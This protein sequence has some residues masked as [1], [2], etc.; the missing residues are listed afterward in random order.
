MPDL[1]EPVGRCRTHLLGRA[2]SG[3]KVRERL[4]QCNQAR[5]L[6]VIVG[7]RDHWRVVGVIGGVGLAQILGQRPHLGLGVGRGQRI[8]LGTHRAENAPCPVW[9]KPR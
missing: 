7:V 6:G 8:D 3:G 9:V 4:F 5:L 1:A 2:V